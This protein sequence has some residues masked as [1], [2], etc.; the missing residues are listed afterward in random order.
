MF[1]NAPVILN[2]LH[3][4]NYIMCCGRAV[5]PR[6]RIFV[7]S[8]NVKDLIFISLP[9]LG[10]SFHFRDAKSFWSSPR[11][12]STSQLNTL[13]H[14]HS[15]PINHVVYMGSY[16]LETGNQIPDTR[17]EKCSEAF[18]SF[19]SLFSS[20]QSLELGYLILGLVSRL[21]AFSVYL[22]PTWLPSYAIGM[23]TGTPAVGPS[24][25]SRTK[26]RSPQISC[27]RDR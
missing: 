20:L 19:W 4:Q 1:L 12:I 24:R 25:S 13:L 6:R 26:D 18:F 21:D 15:W 14:L 27:A 3:L 2:F 17:C 9:V 16:V 5:F 11:P 22:C 10:S 8:F 7:N 23:T